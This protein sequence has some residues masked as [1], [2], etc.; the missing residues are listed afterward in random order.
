LSEKQVKFR[1]KLSCSCSPQVCKHAGPGITKLLEA[2]YAKGKADG[3]RAAI[4]G[5]RKA[6]AKAGIKID[7]KRTPPPGAQRGSRRTQ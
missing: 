6:A 2:A 7:L 4:Q 3:E 5:V 1:L